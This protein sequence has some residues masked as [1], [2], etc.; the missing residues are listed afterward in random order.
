MATMTCDSCDSE[1]DENEVEGGQCEE[2]RSDYS[3]T[4]YCCG[5]IYEDGEDA[6][7]SCGEPL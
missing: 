7:A 5:A 3:G 4:A 2:C 1:V 6:C